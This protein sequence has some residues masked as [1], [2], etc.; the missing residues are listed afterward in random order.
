MA[1]GKERWPIPAGE[2][3]MAPNQWFPLEVLVEGNRIK[4]L[5]NGK[6]AVAATLRLRNR[7][8]GHLALQHLDPQTV[9]EFRKI[10]IQELP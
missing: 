5:V 2:R 1:T 3:L 6:K 10:E 4:S 9:I 7:A 8:Q